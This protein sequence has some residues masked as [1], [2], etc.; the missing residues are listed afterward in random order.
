MNTSDHTLVLWL[1]S[2]P[3]DRATGGKIE[4]NTGPD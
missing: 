4:M 1:S 2:A 3:Y